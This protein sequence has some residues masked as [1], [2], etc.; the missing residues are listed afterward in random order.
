V[1]VRHWG[2]AAVGALIWLVVYVL[3]VAGSLTGR[4][5]TTRAVAPA[6]LPRISA[7]APM[8]GDPSIGLTAATP[9]LH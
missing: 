7:V 8:I 6:S 3:I 1:S 4:E 5:L 2:S 9:D